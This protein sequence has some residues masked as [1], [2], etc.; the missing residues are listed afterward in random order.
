MSKLL[1]LVSGMAAAGSLLLAGQAHAN[2]VTFLPNGVPVQFKYN[3]YETIV[4]AVGDV[5]VGIANFTSIGAPSGSPLYWA[6]GISDGTLLTAK[7]TDLTVSEIL[8]AAGGSTI[9]FTGGHLTVYNVPTG[10]Y[11]PKGP[12]PAFS[13]DSQICAPTGVCPTPWLT[14]DFVPGVVTVDN[15]ATPTF[16]ERTATLVS[17]VTGLV[18]PFSGTGDGQLR[19]TG[20]TAAFKFQPDFSLQSNVQSCPTTNPTFAPNCAAAGTWPLAS[21]DPLVGA[22]RN[23]PEPS[24]IALVGLA[25]LG[26]CASTKR[27]AG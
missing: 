11:V 7:F 14:M 5:L 22:T 6:S 8:P 23:L 19:V 27:R 20:G 10:S 15:P 18:S 13:L 9:Y 21:F 3:N 4:S 17:T 16:D 12:P 25:L 2:P 1:K 24:S 26:V